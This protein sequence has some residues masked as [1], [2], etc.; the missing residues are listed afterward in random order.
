MKRKII[1]FISLIFIGSCASVS[2]PLSTINYSPPLENYIENK[3]I[4]NAPFDETWDKLVSGLSETFY[5]INNIDK[6]S[7]LLNVSFSVKDKP[8]L[9]TDCGITARTFDF[10]GD[11]RKF[12]YEVADSSTYF[13]HSDT[14]PNP[15]IFYVEAFRDT[16]LSGRSNIYVAPN[17][18]NTTTVSV[19]VRYSHLTKLSWDS[20]LYAVLYRTHDKITSAGRQYQ[21]DLES[22][23]FNTNSPLPANAPE[24]RYL[25]V[26]TG[27]FENDII[28]IVRDL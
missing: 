19:N 20:Y 6:E 5:V 25:C 10:V 16:S 24:D 17:D 11:I 3:V 8:S 2:M 23:D 15:N 27:K 22:V 1:S 18:E 4:I 9:Y 21:P 28:D 12:R 7:R 26:P 14:P 13:W